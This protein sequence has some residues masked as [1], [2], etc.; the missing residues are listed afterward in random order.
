VSYKS[1]PFFIVHYTP[2][3]LYTLPGILIVIKLRPTAASRRRLQISFKPVKQIEYTY[4]FSVLQTEQTI[5]NLRLLVVR[6]R[7]YY[8]LFSFLSKIIEIQIKS[9]IYDQ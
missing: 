5:S 2:E 3:S 1:S 8:C 9:A 7:I 4:K 6:A